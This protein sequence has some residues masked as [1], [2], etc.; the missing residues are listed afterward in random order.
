MTVGVDLS[1]DP[2]EAFLAHGSPE[3]VEP[4]D[5]EPHSRI[6]IVIAA[7]LLATFA[8]MTRELLAQD[9]PANPGAAGDLLKA[10]WEKVAPLWLRAVMPAMLHAYELGSTSE[11]AA[12]DVEFLAV[13]Y[14]DALGA[15]A[16]ETSSEAL[17]E[18][19]AAQL[20]SGWDRDLAWRRAVQ[21][22]GLDRKGM[23]VYLTPLLTKPT[24][25]TPM[26]IPEASRKLVSMLLAARSTRMGDNEAYHATQM[27]RHLLWVYQQAQG[28]LPAD[29]MKRWITM[30][31]EM[32]CPVCGP[33]HNVAVPLTA[34]FEVGGSHLVCPGVHPN[35]RCRIELTY[36]EVRTS[37]AKALP[38]FDPTEHPRA[39]AGRFATKPRKPARERTRVADPAAAAEAQRIAD[40]LKAAAETPTDA[41]F[42]LTDTGFPA[43]DTGFPSAD[44]GFVTPDAGF[45]EGEQDGGFGF[46]TIADTGFA[47]ALRARSNVRRVTRIFW[48]PPASEAEEPTQVEEVEEVSIPFEDPE[49]TLSTDPTYI[50]HRRHAVMNA[51]EYYSAVYKHMHSKDG[52]RRFINGFDAN[53][54]L[55][56]PR[57]GTIIDFDATAAGGTDNDGTRWIAPA[58]RVKHGQDEYGVDW[59]GEMIPWLEVKNS[60]NSRLGQEGRNYMDEVMS[61]RYDEADEEYSTVL[62]DTIDRL[63]TD[64]VALIARKKGAVF[65]E[66]FAEWEDEEKLAFMLEGYENEQKEAPASWKSGDKVLPHPWTDAMDAVKTQYAYDIVGEDEAAAELQDATADAIPPDLFVFDGYYGPAQGVVEGKYIVTRMEISRLSLNQKLHLEEEMN[67]RDTH[68]RFDDVRVIHLKP[69]EPAWMPQTPEE[70]RRGLP[71]VDYEG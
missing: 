58:M 70:L 59:I 6:G 62:E 22:Y 31:D 54:E 30:E 8:W 37:F 16:N 33:L 35:C 29:A 5:A 71:P 50:E 49:R 19:F 47:A 48:A 18:G 43:L 10:A 13:Q 23:R 63:G 39:Q 11:L 24:S 46:P 52:M 64:A 53:H 45:A 21:G 26:E 57:P 20:N 34:T 42:P 38:P 69:L 12:G 67:D 14:A 3:Y 32:V 41:G 56:N 7:G 25:F 17:L 40:M 27:A 55:L 44:T 36:P 4:E 51:A 1:I 28:V 2:A 68:L 66:H 15:Y 60:T 61:E 65:P 9:S